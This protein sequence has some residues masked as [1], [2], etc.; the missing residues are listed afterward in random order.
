MWRLPRR[1]RTATL[2]QLLDAIRAAPRSGSGAIEADVERIRRLRGMWFGLP[3]LAPY[4]TCFMR[5]L[6]MYRFLDPGEAEMRLHWVIEP[7]RTAGDRLRS[8]AW[9]TVGGSLVEEVDM[10]GAGVT[11]GLYSHPRAPDERAVRYPSATPGHA[12][13]RA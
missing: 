2:P 10:T 13:Q 11:H 3:A 5:A 7:G 8:H 6:S 12:A 1:M 4:N 9:V